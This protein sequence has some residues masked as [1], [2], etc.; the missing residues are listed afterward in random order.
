MIGLCH[1]CY[2]SGVELNI[3]EGLPICPKCRENI[4]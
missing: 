4:Q 3:I 2:S 1:K